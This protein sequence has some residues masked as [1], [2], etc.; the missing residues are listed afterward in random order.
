MTE[1]LVVLLL[2]G[3][4]IYAM[5]ASFIVGGRRLHLPSGMQGALGHARA[6]VLGAL[7]VGM[8]TGGGAGP[9]GLLDPVG[10]AVVATAAFVARRA[11][12][13]V[14]TVVLAALGAIAVLGMLT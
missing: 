5:R 8:L 9:A 1:G 4:G 10:L 6:A 11:D 14:G 2:A 12:R 7:I 13:G 3:T